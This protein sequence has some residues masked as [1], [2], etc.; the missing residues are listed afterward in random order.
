[1]T[2]N[3]TAYV[4]WWCAPPACTYQNNIAVEPS[5]YMIPFIPCACEVAKKIKAELDAGRKRPGP[6]KPFVERGSWFFHQA[7]SGLR[8]RCPL[9]ISPSWSPSIFGC[10]PNNSLGTSA[11]SIPGPGCPSLRRRGPVPS[12]PLLPSLQRPKQQPRARRSQSLY[13]SGVQSDYDVVS[14]VFFHGSVLS[15]SMRS[16][17]KL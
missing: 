17:P 12:E 14:G 4:S 6:C 3:S 1:M 8:N 16:I 15:L 7:T 9:H 10:S 13:R 5:P 11:A 2:K